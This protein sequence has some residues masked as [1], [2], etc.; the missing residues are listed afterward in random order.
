MRTSD[1]AAVGVMGVS[2]AAG[3]HV[4]AFYPTLAERNEILLP[5]LKE[6]LNHGD[7][8][9]CIVSDD[10]ADSDLDSVR[11]LS[12]HTGQLEVD[13]SGDTYLKGGN[14]SSD[15]MLKYWNSAISQA[16]D[17]GFDFARGAGEMTWAL[18]KMPGVENLVSYESQLNSVLRD[19]PA[20]IVCL[21][22]LGRFSGDLLVE[23][24]KTHPKV[25]LGGIVLE[26]PYY[27]EHNEYLT[28]R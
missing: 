6:G 18:E 23:V 28:S 19:Y 8:C 21:Y 7:K 20:V 10:S 17:D 27:L 26:N 25:I 13:H 1:T 12:Q 14:F 2:L 16:V 3:D 15:R 11:C 5:Y 9:I 22:E 4:C 24:L